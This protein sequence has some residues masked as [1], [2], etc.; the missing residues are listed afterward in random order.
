MVEHGRI[1]IDE[2]NLLFTI[3]IWNKCYVSGIQLQ[4]NL[5]NYLNENKNNTIQTKKQ[6]KETN[7]ILRSV[8]I[9]FRT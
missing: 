3:I 1:R 9:P 5:I 8:L 7:L 4:Q 6:K 2:I